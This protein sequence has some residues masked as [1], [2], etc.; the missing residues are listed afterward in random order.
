MFMTAMAFGVFAGAHSTCIMYG[1]GAPD[2]A[3]GRAKTFIMY[4]RRVPLAARWLRHTSRCRLVGRKRRTRAR[5]F[6]CTRRFPRAGHAEC[7]LEVGGGATGAVGAISGR[8]VGLAAR[9]CR[10]RMGGCTL[11]PG[12]FVSWKGWR[13]STAVKE[14][15]TVL[16]AA[17]AE[18]GGH[19]P[20][21][22]ASCRCDFPGSRAGCRPSGA[23]LQG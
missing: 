18:G 6:L 19:R 16:R 7:R 13:R 9:T 20:L 15:V 17:R 2:T 4:T 22:S 23:D 11:L 12:G 10:G 21:A 3:S 1:K 8:G 5:T 14:I